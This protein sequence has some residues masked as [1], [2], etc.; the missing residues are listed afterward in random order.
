[1]AKKEYRFEVYVSN[2]IR[3][4]LQNIT[5]K[6]GSF[7]GEI[8]TG[9]D[10]QAG[11]LCVAT[12]RLPN[13]GYEEYLKN[14]NSW[15][16]E[17]AK[18]GIV[19]G[20]TGDRTG[21]YA[22]NNYDVAKAS[23]GEAVVNFGGA[24]LGVPVLADERGDFTELMVGEQYNFGKDNFSTLPTDLSATKYAIIENGLWKATASAPNDGSIYAEVLDI[25][26]RFIEGAYDG[27]Q[28]ITLR[29]KR[30]Q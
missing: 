29:I 11:F 25:N 24:T 23:I 13:E 19:E 21:I 10:C 6:Y 26:K 2:S 18:G 5:G 9:A 8:F 4:G 20:F 30:G 15:Y 28:K 17:T 7:S 12:K 1:M 27:G 14:G 3:N 16:M 22:C